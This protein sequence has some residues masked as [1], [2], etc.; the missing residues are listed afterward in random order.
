ME[1]TSIQELDRR[2]QTGRRL[3]ARIVD[4]R[5]L[6]SDTREAMYR[7]YRRYYE[8]TSTAR[9]YADLADKD[10]VLLLS[11]E[12]GVLR[13]FSTLKRIDSQC[14]GGRFRAVFSGDTIV[15]HRFWGEQSLAFT[16][17]RRAGAIKA[18][19]PDAPLYW[20]LI[21]KGHRTYRYLQAFSRRY[22]PHW[23][24]ITPPQVQALMDTLGEQVFGAAYRR[25]LG[26]IQFP[27]SRGQLR[28]KWAEPAVEVLRRPEVQF[29]VQKNPGF[30]QG[31]ELLC[32][33][34]LSPQNLRPM[35]RRV[36]EA[37]MHE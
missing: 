32:L 35:A 28:P 6:A 29:F 1:T 20:L 12:A 4:A 2:F 11:D 27:Q 8:A 30:R 13:G 24:Q 34:E 9:F 7:L 10:E 16:W 37:G 5:T 36:F 23:Q 14:G 21:V 33:T 18:E 22:F 3:V 15:H 31:H 26:I 17:I 19:R 25:D